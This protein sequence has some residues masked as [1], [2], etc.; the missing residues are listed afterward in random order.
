M[1][2]L[3]TAPTPNGY[4]ISIALEELG[5]PYEVHIVDIRV[6]E[7]FKPEFLA[8]SPNN[9]IPAL[10]DP[11]GPAGPIALFESGAILLYLAERYGGL[12]PP[13][14]AGRYLAIQWLMWQMGGLG[15]MLGQA[16][17]FRQYAPTPVPYAIDRYTN[18]AHRLYRVMDTRLAEAD[19]LAGSYSIAD[20]A[21]WPWIRPYKLQGQ[22]LAEFPNL[23]RWFAA[24]A[25]RPAVKRGKRMPEGFDVPMDE[26]AKSVLFGQR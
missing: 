21:C 19:Y 2:Q 1:M 6:G 16:H 23:Q 20:I 24:I 18:E 10:V 15:P 25:A 4:K 14:P 12:L 7:Q 3:Y 5:L 8:I 11:N 13:D 22:D 17:H 26:S 9:R